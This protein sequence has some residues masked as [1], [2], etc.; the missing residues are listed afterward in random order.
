MGERRTR[1]SMPLGDENTQ[2][3][4]GIRSLKGKRGTPAEIR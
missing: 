2:N 1:P 4:E 3:Q